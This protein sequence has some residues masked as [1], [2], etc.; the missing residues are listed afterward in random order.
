MDRDDIYE[1]KMIKDTW[2]S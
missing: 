2:R 1:Q